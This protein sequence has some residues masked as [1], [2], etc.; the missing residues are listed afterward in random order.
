MAYSQLERSDYVFN[1]KDSFSFA[2][3]D[4]VLTGFSPTPG[5]EGS[6][7][8]ETHQDEGVPLSETASRWR[9]ATCSR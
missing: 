5:G 7:A 2:H 9:S 4:R 8:I 1:A 3:P 6:P